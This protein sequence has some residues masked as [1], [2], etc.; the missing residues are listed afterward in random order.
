[1]NNI[2]GNA[3]PVKCRQCDQTFGD[4]G[5]LNRHI[6]CKHTDNPPFHCH[7]CESTFTRD[8]NR[9]LHIKKK[10]EGRKDSRCGLCYRRFTEQ[11]SLGAHIRSV[12]YR[13]KDAICEY[14]GKLFSQRSKLSMHLR[15]AHGIVKKNIQD[16][17]VKNKSGRKRAKKVY[18]VGSVGMPNMLPGAEH[19][20]L[21][22]PRVRYMGAKNLHNTV[23]I[24]RATYITSTNVE[25]AKLITAN[26]SKNRELLV[27]SGFIL[28][29]NVGG[30][31]ETTSNSGENYLDVLALA[32]NMVENNQ[33]TQSILSS[34]KNKN[35]DFMLPDVNP[36][37]S[38]GQNVMQTSVKSTANYGNVDS[39]NAQQ[40]YSTSRSMTGHGSNPQAICGGEIPPLQLLPATSSAAPVP[41]PLHQPSVFDNGVKSNM[42]EQH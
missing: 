30:A 26:E 20:E 19:L 9:T 18:R 40:F 14:C 11:E 24:E 36:L 16:G 7:L 33:I 22:S 27:Q 31:I 32:A 4:K 17:V 10:H 5:T 23:R 12:H 8:D 42:Y 34:M 3:P 28:T 2:H 38:Q 13:C 15:T 21:S 25:N 37:V 41:L 39:G 29:E 35:R 6:R 1:M